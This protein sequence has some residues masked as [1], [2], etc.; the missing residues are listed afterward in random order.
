MDHHLYRC[1][2]GI[3]YI[4]HI[5]LLTHYTPQVERTV[6][7][8]GYHLSFAELFRYPPICICMYGGL[9]L[10]MFFIADLTLIFSLDTCLPSYHVFPL[11]ISYSFYI[12][13]SVWYCG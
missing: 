12:G 4:L 13:T 1:Y 6:S 10:L 5:T 2:T 3:L 8:W 9:C 11:D 7:L